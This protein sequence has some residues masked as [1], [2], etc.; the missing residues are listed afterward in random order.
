MDLY[1][2]RWAKSNGG[3]RGEEALGFGWKTTISCDVEK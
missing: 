2:R 3:T 1:M